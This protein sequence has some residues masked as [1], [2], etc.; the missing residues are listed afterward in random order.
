MN[1]SGL[2]VF[3]LAKNAAKNLDD[4]L[5]GVRGLADEIVVVVDADSRDGTADAARSHTGKIFTRAFDGFSAM[6]GFALAQCTREWALNLDTDERVTP[7]LIRSIEE[8][9]RSSGTSV[10]GYAVNR[11]PYFLGKPIRHGGWYPDWVIRLVKRLQA[12]YPPRQVHERLEVSGQT[13]RLAGHLLHHTATDWK[14]FL[15]KQRRFAALS[16]VRPSVWA[17]CTHPPA[18]FVKSAVFQMGVLDGWRGVAVAYSQAYYS[19][20]KYKNRK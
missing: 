12:A 17:R 7:E 11:L 20:Y 15:E 2:S 8:V 5:A 10:S 18:A 19:Y 14:I 4:C 3:V 16:D 9:K 1:E 6:K 13:S